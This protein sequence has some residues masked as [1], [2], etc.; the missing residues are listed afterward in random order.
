MN[1]NLDFPAASVLIRSPRATRNSPTRSRQHGLGHRPVSASSH[2]VNFEDFEVRSEY[3]ASRDRSRL[4]RPS[5]T[6]HHGRFVDQGGD[7]DGRYSQDRYGDVDRQHYRGE[8][9][10]SRGSGYPARLFYSGNHEFDDRQ[11][12][13]SVYSYESGPTG[14]RDEECG[15]DGA[16]RRNQ[17]WHGDRF[18]APV[19][20]YDLD[21][22]LE[23][24]E[25]RRE[26]E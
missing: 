23:D 9:G 22:R 20:R 16:F 10:P 17:A 7:Y 15:R 8:S 3:R 18:H 6:G 5:S 12:R 24:E 1:G 13:Q 21:W 25:R 19:L 26:E 4:R 14:R 2:R 11:W